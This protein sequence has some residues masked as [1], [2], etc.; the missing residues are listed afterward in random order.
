M[1]RSIFFTPGKKFL[2]MFASLAR[3]LVSDLR[4]DKLQ[5]PS[6]CP[7]TTPDAEESFVYSNE[8]RRALLACYAL[9]AM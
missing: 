8:S 4:L 3:S 7:S 5:G 2:I 1:L 9:T 6:W